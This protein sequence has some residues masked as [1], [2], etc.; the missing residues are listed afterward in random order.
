MDGNLPPNVTRDNIRLDYAMKCCEST[1]PLHIETTHAKIPGIG[2]KYH[3]MSGR[4]KASL[5]VGENSYS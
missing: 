3:E 4:P 5:S 1:V 2:L